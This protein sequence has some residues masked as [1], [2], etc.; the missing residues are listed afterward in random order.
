VILDRECRRSQNEASPSVPP[1]L[2]ADVTTTAATIKLT[3]SVSDVGSGV[4]VA[5]CNGVPVTPV[6]G[7][8][9]CTVPLRPGRNTVVLVARD[10]AGNNVSAGVRVTRTGTP[11]T[12]TIAPGTRTLL[13]DEAAT[14]SLSDDYGLNVAGATWE[15]SD[16]NVVSLSTDDPPVLTALAAGSTTITATKSGL[17]AN[18]T[19]TVV[20]GTSLLDRSTRWS[21]AP[22]PGLEMTLPIYT[23]RVDETVPDLFTVET[24]AVTNASTVRGLTAS[25]EQRWV[26]AAPDSR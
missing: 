12:L 6:S 21:V 25:G 2:T 1:S 15:A 14:L 16:P 5:S 3:G 10:A 23:H 22:T 20:S 24:D 8:V 4:S 7:Q 17:S 18:A 13:V 19:L 26:E 11:T 9:T